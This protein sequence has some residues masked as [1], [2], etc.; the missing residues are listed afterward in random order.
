VVAGRYS[1][2]QKNW[3]RPLKIGKLNFGPG[4]PEY[5]NILVHFG[6]AS[7]L[8]GHY[9]V[10]AQMFRRYLQTEQ[11]ISNVPS[12][13]RAVAAAELANVSVQQHKYSEAQPWF[14]N[15]LAVFNSVPEEAPLMR[16]LVLSYLGDVV[17][18]SYSPR[19]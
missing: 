6:Q 4:G 5:G 15:A 13:S 17:P 1:E 12:T 2:G 18:C 14:D 8:F 7:A 9:D 10:T 16:S 19:R 11:R 3:N